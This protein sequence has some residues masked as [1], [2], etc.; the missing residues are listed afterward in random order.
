MMVSFELRG[1]EV[2]V[3]RFVKRL[4]VWYLA[5]SLGG[6]ESILSYPLLSSHIGMS[7]K[8]LKMLGVTASTVRLSVGVED[9]ADLLADVVSAL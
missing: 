4:K 8:R 1:G 9:A 6:V 3:D 5:T 7:A 2:A